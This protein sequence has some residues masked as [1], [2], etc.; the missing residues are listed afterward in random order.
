[1]AKKQFGTTDALGKTMLLKDGDQFVP[2]A[3]T[4]VAKNARKILLLNSMFY[5]HSK[6]PKKKMPI[7]KTGLTFS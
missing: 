5:S 4:G 3:V 2:Y 1:M 7:M 6:Y